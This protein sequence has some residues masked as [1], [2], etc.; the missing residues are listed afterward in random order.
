MQSQYLNTQPD[1][2]DDGQLAKPLAA[3]HQ[4]WEAQR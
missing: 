3:Q 4:Q 2:D 1:N